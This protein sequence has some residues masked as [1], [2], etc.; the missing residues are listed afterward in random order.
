MW[1]RNGKIINPKNVFF[2]EKVRADKNINCFGALISPGF[3]DIQINGKLN[4]I[5]PDYVNGLS[6]FQMLIQFC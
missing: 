5:S 2:D 6:D 1:V 3:I 4:Q